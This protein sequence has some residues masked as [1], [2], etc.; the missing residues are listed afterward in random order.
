MNVLVIPEDFRK[1]QFILHPII[2]AMFT[3]LGKP[4]IVEVLKDPSIGGIVQALKVDVLEEIVRDN[5]WKVDLFLLCVDRDAEAGRRLVLDRLEQHFAK[6]LGPGKFLAAENA[7]QE[8]EVW[9]LA[10][11]DLMQGWNWQEIRQERD[12]KEAYFMK[13]AAARGLKDDP[14]EGRKTM[15]IEAARKYRRIYSR[16]REDIQVLEKRLETWINEQTVLS[17]EAAFKSL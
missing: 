8:L 1:D 10:G 6:K 15:G 2:S 14:G 5:Q 13:L 11:Q 9:V 3:K 7:W 17:W 4:A 16:C 12:P